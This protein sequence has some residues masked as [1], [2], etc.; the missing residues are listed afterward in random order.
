MKIYKGKYGILLQNQ[1][2]KNRYNID[3]DPGK[4]KYDVPGNKNCITYKNVSIK[5]TKT[6]TVYCG[7]IF[8]FLSSKDLEIII[9][10]YQVKLK[11]KSIYYRLFFIKKFRYFFYRTQKKF[12]FKN[13]RG[14]KVFCK[15]IKISIYEKSKS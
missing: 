15:W 14:V 4:Q 10:K 3:Y 8:N 11:K 1:I 12:K 9:V 7:D 6:N 13:I 5:T 2:I